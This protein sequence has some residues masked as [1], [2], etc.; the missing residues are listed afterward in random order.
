[1]REPKVFSSAYSKVPTRQKHTLM[2]ITLV[3]VFALSMMSKRKNVDGWKKGKK[4]RMML[5]R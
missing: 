3:V 5:T 4:V 2:T 1:M